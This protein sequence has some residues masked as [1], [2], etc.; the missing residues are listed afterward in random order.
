MSLQNKVGR[1]F[2]D[3][4]DVAVSGL[5]QD[6][7]MKNNENNW[8]LSD[9]QLKELAGVVKSSLTRSFDRGVDVLIKTITEK[10]D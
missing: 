2:L 8:N 3:V 10:D 4:K 9:D 1:I 7:I 5:T 6:I